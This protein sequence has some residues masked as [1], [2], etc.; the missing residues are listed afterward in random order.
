M[1]GDSVLITGSTGFVGSHLTRRLVKEGWQVHVVVRPGSKTA[2]LSDVIEHLAV[3]CHDGSTAGM[4]DLVRQVKPAL[5]F[6]LASYFRAEHELDEV[7]P[8]IR[9]NVIFTAQLIEAMV[10]NKVYR[11]VNTGTSWQHYQNKTYSPVCLYAA[12]KQAAEAIVAYY[13]QAYPFRCITL[14]LFDTYGPDDP[15]DKLLSKLRSCATSGEPLAMS[16]GEQLIDLVYIDDVVQAFLC[17]AERL[18]KGRVVG[19]ELYAVTSG[20]QVTL[21]EIVETYCR[22][23]NT[24]LFIEWGGRPYRRREVMRPW[25][26]GVQLPGWRPT[27]S[28]EEGLA[29]L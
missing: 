28:L 24:S 2:S 13:E 19:H 16:P 26:K 15:R 27:V 20:H 21:R 22:V 29:R 11:L 14:K 4:L 7:E 17:A 3:H 12:T 8:M 6:H 5:V 23:R 18:L 10:R 9:S 1:M 25:V